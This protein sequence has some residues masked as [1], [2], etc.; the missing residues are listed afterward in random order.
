M[1]RIV[2]VIKILLI[3]ILHVFVRAL[4]SA[5]ELRRHS[6]L[7][8]PFRLHAGS[9]V[10]IER[11]LP[12][13]N[14]F[15]GFFFPD[16]ILLIFQKGRNLKIC[17]CHTVVQKPGRILHRPRLLSIAAL[18]SSHKAYDAAHAAGRNQSRYHFLF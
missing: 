16:S 8:F 14:S 13:K 4:L 3:N 10:A 9:N 18:C 12:G 17:S 2:A 7:F 6:V 5:H 15:Q 1:K 11:K